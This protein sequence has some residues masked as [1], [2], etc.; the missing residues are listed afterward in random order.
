[1]KKPTTRIQCNDYRFFSLLITLYV[2]FSLTSIGLGYKLVTIHFLYISGAA[3]VL[4]FRY[5]LGGIIADIYP[6]NLA[7]KQVWNLPIA[8]FVFSFLSL[9]VI[10]LPSPASW[11]HQAAYLFVLGNALKIT[12]I[13]TIGLILGI[14]VNMYI[15]KK[16]AL[17]FLGKFF[18]IRVFISSSLGELT[19]NVIALPL[20]F[21]GKIPIE[22][23]ATLVVYDYTTQVVFILILTP[24]F[25]IIRN[26]IVK[27]EVDI[28]EQSK[29]IF[30]PFKLTN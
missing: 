13:A 4:P 12:T 19:Q 28:V 30:N 21:W 9:I 18:A 5:L 25:S 16:L 23:I 22:K 15:V 20:I 26:L 8:C 24:F 29:I 3:V 17:R 2:T 14:S 6:Y 1:M 11:N 27:Y 10:H 7:K